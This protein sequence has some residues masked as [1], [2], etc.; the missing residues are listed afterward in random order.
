MRFKIPD[1][2]KVKE[3]VLLVKHMTDMSKVPDEQ[4]WDAVQKLVDTGNWKYFEEVLRRERER[5]MKELV[6]SDNQKEADRIKGRIKTL[7]W[8]LQFGGFVNKV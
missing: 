7:D 8:L 2:L 4:L 3:E 5:F 1:W 6:L